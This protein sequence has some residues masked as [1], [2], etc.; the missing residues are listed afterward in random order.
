[1][2]SVATLAVKLAN[3]AEAEGRAFARASVMLTVILLLLI[4]ASIIMLAGGLLLFIALYVGLVEIM[5]PGFALLIIGLAL[6]VLGL[7][8]GMI[9]GLYF[10]ARKGTR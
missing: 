4:A 6:L 3:L 5:H 7:L 2:K 8:M 10:Q 1:M 9:A